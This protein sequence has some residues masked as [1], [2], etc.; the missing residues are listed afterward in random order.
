MTV[1]GTEVP[2]GPVRL[3]APF[4]QPAEGSCGLGGRNGP[5]NGWSR[6]EV[7]CQTSRGMT[8]SL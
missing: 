6:T 4:P 1:Q 3:C 7:T 2:A 8:G 5:H